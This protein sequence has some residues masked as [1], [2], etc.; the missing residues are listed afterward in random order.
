MDISS[1]SGSILKRNNKKKCL[2]NSFCVRIAQVYFRSMEDKE[3]PVSNFNMKFLT[4]FV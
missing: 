3:N 2:R 4:D 1:V